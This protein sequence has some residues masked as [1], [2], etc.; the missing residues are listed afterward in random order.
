MNKKLLMLGLIPLALCLVTTSVSASAQILNKDV[1]KDS[2]SDTQTNT[3]DLPSPY[4]PFTQVKIVSTMTWEEHWVNIIVLDASWNMHLNVKGVN[5]GTVQVEFWFWNDVSGE[6]VYAGVSSQ[7]LSSV[8]G[9]ND[10]V[11]AGMETYMNSIISKET[12]EISVLDPLTGE[13]MT[14]EYT[15][16]THSIFK[17]VNGELLFEKHWVIQR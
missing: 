1:G 12:F 9:F 13:W 3:M 4:Y 14:S 5:R 8:W 16:I 17:W 15:V 10:L 7:L 2:G 11:K 6:W